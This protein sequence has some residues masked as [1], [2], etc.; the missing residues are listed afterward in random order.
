MLMR[1]INNGVPPLE[2]IPVEERRA[3]PEKYQPPWALDTTGFERVTEAEITSA[4]GAKFPVKIY[5][6]D[7]KVHGDGPYGVHLNFHGGGFVMGSL[8][9]E[10]TICMSMRD[11]AGIVVIDV[12]YR[13][14]PEVIF[15]KP[16]EDGWAALKWVRSSAQELNIR[17]DSISIGGISAG[18][19]ISLVLQHLARDEGIPLVLCMPTVPGSDPVLAYTHYT[20]SPYRSFIE[21]AHGPVLGW[22]TLRYFGSYCFPPDCRAERLAMIPDWWVGTINAPNWEGLCDT[23]LRTGECDPLRDEGEAY[24]R[25]LLETGN[26]VTMKRYI[27]CPHTF[28]FFP[29]LRQK[30]EWDADSI[31]AL[32]A[33]HG[34]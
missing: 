32:K 8:L 25:K 33:A 9:N 14:C 17:R 28:M 34:S 29:E 21:Y 18:A 11:G 16:F 30:M 20:D 22:P 4:D 31:R 15:N 10:S 13:H 23:L 12:N 3:H 27:G 2:S 19:N 5:H 1:G 24:G 7:P 26:K 6:P